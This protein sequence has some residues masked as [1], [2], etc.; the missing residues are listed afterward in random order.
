MLLW[1]VRGQLHAHH[2]VSGVAGGGEGSPP[3]AG[4]VEGHSVGWSLGDV[5]SL[6]RL[7]PHLYD[8]HCPII[9]VVDRESSC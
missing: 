3:V 9:L 6:A 5:V 2:E 8:K 1:L 4:L 7:Q